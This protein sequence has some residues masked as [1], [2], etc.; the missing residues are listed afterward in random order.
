[1]DGLKMLK[2]EFVRKLYESSKEGHDFFHVERVH[3]F[4]MKIAEKEKADSEIVDA[5]AW[6]HDIARAKE[7]R[8]ECE[9]HAAEGAK[10]AKKILSEI[11]FPKE[12]IEAVAHAIE[13]HRFSKGKQ[14]ETTE[15]K[16]LQEADRLD[17]I[18]AICI[19]RVFMYNGHRGLPMYEPG[20]E[21]DK[22]YHGQDTNAINHFYEKVLKIKP[23]TFHTKIGKEMAKERYAFIQKFLKRFKEEWDAKI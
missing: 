3:R 18:G 21:P 7:D 5:A 8:A 2:E 14:A 17:A 19:A 4:A 12:K 10:M 11:D 13:V 1:M 22:E 15:A 16:I 6:L 23:E 20:R 9:C